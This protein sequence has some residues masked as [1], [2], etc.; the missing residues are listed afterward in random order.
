MKTTGLTLSE[1]LATGRPF[2]HGSWGYWM[3]PD[4]SVSIYPISEALLPVWQVKE[5]EKPPM[6]VWLNEEG[7][8]SVSPNG[9]CFD[10]DKTDITE[11]L[12]VALA[13]YLR[14]EG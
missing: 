13:P 9:P 2:K 12:A 7:K 14:G 11:A 4:D 1:A 8:L 10:D 6:R 3:N 5:E